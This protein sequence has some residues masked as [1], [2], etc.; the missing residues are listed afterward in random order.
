M[1]CY[2][3]TSALE[4]ILVVIFYVALPLIEKSF[5]MHARLNFDFV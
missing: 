3:R 2:A 4:K 5:E 1:P